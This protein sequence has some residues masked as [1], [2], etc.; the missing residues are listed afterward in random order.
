MF[1]S[2]LCQVTEYDPDVLE[3]LIGLASRNCSR[4][5]EREDALA[6]CLRWAMRMPCSPDPDR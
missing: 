3:P 2:I 6:R 4:G 5:V 1:D